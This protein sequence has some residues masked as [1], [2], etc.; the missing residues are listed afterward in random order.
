MGFQTYRYYRWQILIGQRFR[1]L[2]V[3][4]HLDFLIF[5]CEVVDFEC[6]SQEKAGA[7]G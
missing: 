5:Q 2:S 1:G 6:D 3:H 4:G 7:K